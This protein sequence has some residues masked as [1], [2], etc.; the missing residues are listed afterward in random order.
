MYVDVRH[1]RSFRD[2]RAAFGWLI[3]FGAGLLFATVAGAT[4]RGIAD[5]IQHGIGRLPRSVFEVILVLVQVA[6]ILVLL[7]TP[8][9][10]LVMRRFCVA[11][12]RRARAVARSPRVL[13]GPAPPA[14]PVVGARRGRRGRPDQVSWPPTSVLAGCTALAVT[15]TASLRRPWRRAVWFLLGL[16]IALRVV[17]SASAPVDVV[18]AVGIGGVVGSGIMLGLGRTAGRLTPHGVRVTLAELRPPAGRRARAARRDP[19]DVPRDLGRRPV[20]IRVLEEHGW[21]SARLDQ[22]YRRLRWRDVGETTVDPDPLRLV[23][24]EAM[25]LLLAASRDVRVPTVRAVATAPRGESAARGGRRRRRA[26]ERPR[27]ARPTTSWTRRG[28]RSSSCTT[29]GSR[30]GSWT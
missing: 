21:S 24:T 18:L 17:T 8:L 4:M 5:D 7:V 19:L 1:R 12:P 23:T 6:Y 30:T 25:T 2:A 26:A 27:R 14:D 15:T 9:V 20:D 10:L 16:L 28:R 3:V 22:A 11:G 29:P 13:A